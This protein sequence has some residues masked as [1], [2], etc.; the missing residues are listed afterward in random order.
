MIL[1]HKTYKQFIR[2][3]FALFISTFFFACNPTKH[4]KPN[5][6][7]L[8]KSSVRIDNNSID[9]DD[10]KNYIKQKHNKKILGVFRFHLGVYNLANKKNSIDKKNVGEAPVLYD[11]LL[12]HRS[13]NQLSLYLNNKGYFENLVTYKESYI[14]DKKVKV[15]YHIKTGEPYIVNSIKYEV[16]DTILYNYLVLKHYKSNIKIDK[17][18]DLDVL[19][20]ERERIR[21]VI[22]NEGYFGFTKEYVE[23]LVDTTIEK[24]KVGITIKVLN[25]R[26]K[27]KNEINENEIVDHKRYSINAINVFI[28]K[29]FL[30]KNVNT[31]DTISYKKIFIGHEDELIYRPKM[32]NHAINIKPNEDYSLEDQQF[33]YKYLTELGLFRTVNIQFNNAE[34]IQ[35]DDKKNKLDVN[36]YLT[37][38]KIKSLSLEATGTNSGG[39]LGIKGGLVFVNKNLFNGGEKL[40]FRLNGGLEAQQ[41]IN[42]SSEQVEFL[43]LPFNTI[44]F[45]PEVNL[46]FPRFLLPFLSNYNFAKSINPKTSLNYLLNYQNRPEY[47]RNLTQ[48]TFG[49]FWNQGRFVK[50]Y[51]NPISISLIKI[52][53]NSEFKNRIEEE[54]NP[55]IVNSFTDHFINSTNYTLVYSNHTY[56]KVRDFQ[57]F[58]FNIEGAGNAHTLYDKLIGSERNENGSFEIFEI[59]YAQFV[60]ADLDYRYYNQSPSGNLVSRIAFG[61]GKPYGNL[62]V[63]PFEKSYFGGGANGIRAWQARTLGP[64]S[65]P[66]SLISSQFVNQLGEIK[67]EGNLE[68]RFDITK[69]FEGAIFVDAGNI[70]ITRPDTQRP[71]AEIKLDRFWQDLAVGTG[72]GLRLDFNFF[73]FRFDLAAKL[74]DPS[75]E[76]PQEFKLQWRTPNLNL[77]IGYP[78]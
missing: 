33:T 69:L 8:Q 39:N 56:N 60:K 64:G 42:Q 36:I 34:T 27:S 22:R 48:F 21:D 47:T 70:W 50:H 66:D 31:F 38:L 54:N 1:N 45:G 32:I 23:F 51:F 9:K 15:K 26:V 11:S 67:I 7:F 58:R 52:N 62:E 16:E 53:L 2:A 49:Y 71:N 77:G 3:I 19:D 6:I 72:I 65:L 13:A 76:K 73:L 28:S 44:E 4:L 63:L 17:P 24:R 14:G 57:F 20:K 40:T 41:L 55:F 12:T 25:K 43:G 59:Q 5:E 10:L 68:Y 74:K 46:E 29:D 75:S 18:L 78:F 30:N 35:N 37:P 61:I